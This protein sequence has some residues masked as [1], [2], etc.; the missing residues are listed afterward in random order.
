MTSLAEVAALPAARREQ[1]KLLELKQLTV[2]YGAGD[3][4]V[5][6]VD[7]VDLAIHEG[8]VVGLAGE[9]GCG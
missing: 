3:R 5:R 4:P 8:E 2:D 6:A 9:S 7:G 1:P